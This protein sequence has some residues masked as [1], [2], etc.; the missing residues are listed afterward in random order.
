MTN[1]L[2]VPHSNPL[3]GR[4]ASPDRGVLGKFV[5][6]ALKAL[7]IGG[8]AIW[9]YNAIP[10]LQSRVNAAGGWIRNTVTGHVDRVRN[11]YHAPGAGVAKGGE[12]AL[13]D[14]GMAKAAGAAKIEAGAKDAGGATNQ[15]VA[16]AGPDAAKIAAEGKMSFGPANAAARAPRPG[17]GNFVE[18]LQ[19]Q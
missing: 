13:K 7:L 6:G 10:G 9:A 14:A 16:K 12:Q 15:A 19:Q 5:R 8:L 11:W 18:P 17:D 1:R 3:E 2:E 4:D